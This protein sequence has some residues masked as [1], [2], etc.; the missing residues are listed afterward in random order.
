MW[1]REAVHVDTDLGDHDLSRAGLDARDRHQQ[2]P[3]PTE[4]G[5]QLIDPSVESSFDVGEVVDVVEDR[6]HQGRVVLTAAAGHG[7]TQLE[8]LAA[9]LPDGEIREGLGVAFTVTQRW[10]DPPGRDP[11]DVRHDR[12][13]YDLGVLEQLLQP[14]QL[15]TLCVADPASR[16]GHVVGPTPNYIALGGPAARPGVDWCDGIAVVGSRD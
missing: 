6:A 15:L 10:Q 16:A 12:V 1:G 5:D 2:L 13:E 14:L 4:R 3:G 7:L 9:Q 11:V 8:H